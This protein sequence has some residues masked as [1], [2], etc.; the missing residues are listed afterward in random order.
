MTGNFQLHAALTDVEERAGVAFS[1]MKGLINLFSKKAPNVADLKG[2]TTI[3]ILMVRGYA[4][5]T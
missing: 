5:E 3:D 1:G 2:L 4:R